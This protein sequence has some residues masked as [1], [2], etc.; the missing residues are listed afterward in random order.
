[1]RT[2]EQRGVGAGLGSHYLLWIHVGAFALA[3]HASTTRLGSHT[4]TH[5]R[6]GVHT[7]SRRSARCA[8]CEAS[9]ALASSLM[10]SSAARTL[11]RSRCTASRSSRSSASM[12]TIYTPRRG[13]AR[14]GGGGKERERN[15]EQRRTADGR[16]RRYTW[17]LPA[18]LGEFLY[19]LAKRGNTSTESRVLS[20]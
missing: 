11:S 19:A 17:P 14:V 3:L 20:S 8:S 1:M 15:G 2:G 18:L 7:A 16:T 13:V 6:G 4:H 9:A 5:T 10:A 12:R